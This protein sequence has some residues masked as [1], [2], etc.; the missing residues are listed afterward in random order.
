MSRRFACNA[1][2][3]FFLNAP[4]LAFPYQTDP[5]ELTPIATSAPEK[6]AE[7]L[8]QQA[9]K[10][11][12]D[13]SFP[14][15]HQRLFEAVPLWQQ[16]HRTARAV[17]SLTHLAEVDQRAGRW[18]DALK[19][20]RAALQFSSLRGSPKAAALNSVAS[21]YTSLN[22]FHLA[23][24][25]YQRSLK[26]AYQIKDRTNEVTALAGLAAV[27][28]EQR[29]LTS[30]RTFLDKAQLLAQQMKDQKT[31]AITLFLAGRVFQL[32]GQNE[33]AY[34]AIEQALGL[35]EKMGERE[36]QVPLLCL[37]SGLNLA[38]GRPQAA[39]EQAA[40]AVQLADLLKTGE[41][42]WRAHLAVAKARHALGQV[43]EAIKSYYRSYSMVE[44]QRLAHFSADA[45]KVAL[46]AE[47]Q[48]PYRE[49]A[50]LW[51]ERGRID[52]AFFIIERTRARATLDALAQQRE[53]AP[54]EPVSEATLRVLTEQVNRLRAEL[55]SSTSSGPKLAAQ[56]AELTEAM[57]RL[58]EVRW[59][60][61]RHKP[62]TTPLDLKQ[63][64]KLL[65]PKEV[66]LNFV[67]GKPQSYVWRI[68]QNDVTGALLPNQKEIEEKLHLYLTA[69]TAKPQNRQIE[70]E[71]VRQK[72]LGDELFRLLLGPFSGRLEAG[73]QLIIVPDGLL[74]Y[75]PFESLVHDGRYLLESHPVNY[76][77]SASVLGLLRQARDVSEAQGQMEL[78]AFGDPISGLPQQT[79][80]RKTRGRED[81]MRESWSAS[82]FRF[83]P[84]PNTRNE[85][86][87][88][89]AFFPPERQRLY[90]GAAMTEEAFRREPLDRYRRLHF[91]TH[92]LIDEQLPSRSG[93]VLSL[94]QA[95]TEDGFL[96]VTEITDL[97]LNCDL[98]VLSACQS[99]RG[100]LVSGEGIV[101]LTRAFLYAGARRITVSLWNVSDLSTARLMTDFYQHLNA[102]LDPAAALRQAK[103]DMIKRGKASRHPYYWA[104]FVLVGKS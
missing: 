42:Q 80:G 41:T 46:L 104:S 21:L 95:A 54:L 64:Q 56:Q 77:P 75:L 87:A 45:F 65:Q 50:A 92:S 100:Q 88:I 103:L 62:Y 81:V 98:V 7:L 27:Y 12:E 4:L 40:Q 90:L 57:Q 22:Q 51:I 86:L 48:T 10:F 47:R 53:A 34:R 14:L 17:Q 20:Y 13:K 35:Y 99:G 78:L 67:L 37:L 52:E 1:L 63:T 91:A 38:M 18:Q 39:L 89:S 85:V 24:E 15:A 82:N 59:E 79:K 43:E 96:D 11:V 16:A 73:Q 30:A 102:Q 8:Y 44:K 97:K 83:P 3:V 2:L 33:K 32:Q 55:R 70:R 69:L 26:L 19:C 31:T 6:K 84:L 68:T 29:Q 93:V 94:A 72:K 58:E 71:V 9:M 49:L 74:S 76:V 5:I 60:M 101:G 36:Q 66:L 28:L 25:Y 23:Q 61:E